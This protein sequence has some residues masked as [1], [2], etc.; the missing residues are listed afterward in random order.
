MAPQI[1]AVLFDLDG[2]LVETHIDFPAMKRAVESLSPD[3]GVPV[4]VVTGKDILGIIYTSVAWLDGAGRAGDEFR[5]RAFDEL[6]RLEVEGCRNPV[7]IPG[8]HRVLGE[9]ARR[10]IR[11][12]IVTRNCRKV[13]EDLLETFGL[14]AGVLLTRDD[15]PRV[16]PDPDHLGRAL[17]KLGVE[18]DRSIMVGDHWM[19]IRAGVE[20]GCR[21]TVGVLYGRTSDFYAPAPPTYLAASISDILDWI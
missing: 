19:D 14:D 8:A 20:A 7:E 4:D 18:P 21:L 16:K 9:L 5:K 1:S 11:T 2:T 17:D 15:V 12:G 10:G 6:E 3:A 13:A